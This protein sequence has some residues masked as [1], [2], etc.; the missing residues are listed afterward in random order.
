[1]YSTARHIT[2]AT[3]IQQLNPGGPEH[4]APTNITESVLAGV[5]IKSEARPARAGVQ[6]KRVA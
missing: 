1:M 5:F 2:R 3:E 4:R 6:L